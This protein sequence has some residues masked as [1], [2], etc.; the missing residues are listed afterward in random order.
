MQAYSCCCQSISWSEVQ[1]ILAGES[2]EAED[3]ERPQPGKRPRQVSN[4]IDYEDGWE[5][6]AMQAQGSGKG[7]KQKESQEQL[8]DKSDDGQQPPTGQKRRLSKGSSQEVPGNAAFQAAKRARCIISDDED[9]HDV[10]QPRRS[11]R[12]HSSR[13]ASPD[14]PG[15]SKV[16]RLFAEE[17]LD[18]V[19]E[20][21]EGSRRRK[22]TKVDA[23]SIRKRMQLNQQRLH[24]VR[25]SPL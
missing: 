7:H 21:A 5:T 6:A 2:A 12:Q 9:E 11:R 25:C 15:L 24:E 17:G 14:Q 22:S 1:S 23:G 18:P 19:K 4:I 3:E 8:E 20:G 13:A 16:S 10:Q